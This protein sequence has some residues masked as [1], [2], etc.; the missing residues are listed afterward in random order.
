[1]R[2]RFILFKYLLSEAWPELPP[3]VRRYLSKGLKLPD[4]LSEIQTT[5]KLQ[6]KQLQAQ[7]EDKFIDLLHL[8]RDPTTAAIE[9]GYSKTYAENIRWTKLQSPKFIAKVKEKYNGN[10]TWMLPLIHQLESKQINL[11][12]KQADRLE[13][14]AEIAEDIDKQTELTNKAL[15]ILAKP[16]HAS[17]Q[18]KQS[19]GV[20]ATEGQ[21]QINVVN[22]DK[23]QALIHN[24]HADMIN[25]KHDTD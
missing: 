6:T 11:S 8:Y 21:Q 17:K 12:L 19:T 24:N 25:P 22:I 15:N 10:S 13:K 3:L 2:G 16:V 7:I 18:I 14:Q 9:A 20:L 5:P 23:I 4:D 1:M